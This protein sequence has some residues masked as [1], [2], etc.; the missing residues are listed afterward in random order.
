M[1]KLD[2]DI[3]TQI[4]DSYKQGLTSKEAGCKFD[5]S[6]KVVLRVLRN[7]GVAVRKKGRAALSE[8]C[9]TSICLRFMN[10]ESRQGI[11]RTI[12]LSPFVVSLV[13]V[14]RRKWIEDKLKPVSL[15]V[16]KDKPKPVR[17]PIRVPVFE[18]KPKRLPDWKEC[19]DDLFDYMGKCGV[20]PEATIYTD[21]DPKYKNWAWKPSVR[22]I[23]E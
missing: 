14:E 22:E 4:I 2:P 17:V 6:V 9:K 19:H 21:A 12:D 18:D 11:A 7:N 8:E 13:I 16:F 1:I 23:I 10:G 15:P 3:E 20:V 5:V